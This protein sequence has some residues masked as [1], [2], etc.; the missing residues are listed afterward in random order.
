MHD[1]FF[2][3][4]SF[5]IAFCTALYA[6]PVVI[7]IA[8]ALKMF[9]QPNGRSSAKLAVPTLGGIAIFLSFILAATIGVDGYIF[10]GLNS[11]FA[12]VLL[13]FFV[14]LK[15]DIL[16]IS[17]YKKIA[18]ELITAAILIFLADIH[19]TN[20]HGFLGIEEI[21]Y[22][23]GAILTAFVMIVFINA[24]NLIDGIDGLAAGLSIFATTIFGVWFF[25]CG[26]FEYA[27]LSFSLVGALA[28]FFR[29]NVYGEK[30]KIFMG[31]T[32]SLILG[33]VLSIIVIK[34]NELNVDQTMPFAIA[35]APAVSFAILIYPL[36]DTLR[37]FTIRLL[38]KRSPF[39]PDK[40]HIHHRLLTLGFSHKQAAFTIIGV[41]IAFVVPVFLLQN[42]GIAWLMVFNILLCLFLFM[43]P[44]LFIQSRQLIK[45]NDPHQQILFPKSAGKLLKRMSL[46]TIEQKPQ[47]VKI[48]LRKF[49]TQLQRLNFW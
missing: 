39:S 17:A 21:G 7:R 9:D 14:G 6:V 16:N 24:Y 11:I 46:I 32:G 30:N 8:H 12:A 34:F 38:H 23:P 42:I 40:N 44:A 43:I 29:Y 49:H 45:E 10:P 47:P 15:D 33:T 18:A 41:N 26:H 35:S 20:L 25:I 37:V 36:V 13:M 28:G 19:F 31:D 22:I 2:V 1:L 3:I 27:V 5:V 4:L 48:K